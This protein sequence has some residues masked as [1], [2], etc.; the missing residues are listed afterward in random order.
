MSEETKAATATAEKPAK[1]EKAAEPEKP[2]N[3]DIF[4]S[5]TTRITRKAWDLYKTYS[6]N[7]FEKFRTVEVRAQLEC[8]SIDGAEDIQKQ[9]VEAGVKEISRTEET[10]HFTATMEQIQTVIKQP[11]A[12][13][14]DMAEI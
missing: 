6:K 13:L 11:P 7:K 4:Q 3:T 12:L 9:L 1:E 10:L 5:C 2:F 14:L 8:R